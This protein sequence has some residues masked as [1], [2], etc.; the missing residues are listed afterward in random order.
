MVYAALGLGSLLGIV[1]SWRSGHAA[2]RLMAIV[3]M[4]YPWSTA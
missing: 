4:V 3:T 1:L 2:V